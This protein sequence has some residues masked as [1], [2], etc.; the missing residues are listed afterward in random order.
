MPRHLLVA[1]VLSISFPAAAQTTAPSL[2]RFPYLSTPPNVAESVWLNFRGSA[3]Y[4]SSQN[5]LRFTPDGHNFDTC[6]ATTAQVEAAS[7]DAASAL[8][9]ESAARQAGDAASLAAVTSA[10]NDATSAL[11]LETAAR[12][13]ADSAASSALANEIT[14]RTNGDAANTAAVSALTSRVTSVETNYMTVAAANTAIATMQA[15]IASNAGGIT[16]LTTR[17]TALETNSATK[18]ELATAQSTLNARIDGLQKRACGTA[19]IS[20]LSVPLAGISSETA[21]AIAGVPVGTSCDSGAAS[22]MPLGARPDAIVT[23]AGTVRLRF[24]SN[25]GLLSVAIAIPN[26]TYR[27]CCDM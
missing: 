20:G 16:N 13:S 2:L 14:A 12:Q 5:C 10:R 3:F 11:A 9:S 15:S 7:D 1:V 23:T 17:V 21:I 22:F 24:V 26:G 6:N 18:A 19:T 8:A 25:G 27:V 4:D